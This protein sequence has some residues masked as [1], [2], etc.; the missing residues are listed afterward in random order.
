MKIVKSLEQS[1]LLIKGVSEKIQNEAKE[2][3][4][5][6]LRMLLGKLGARLIGNLLTAKGA[7]RA[8]KGTIRAG[9]NFWCHVIL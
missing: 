3:K 4:G 2:Q 5:R 9:Q 7:I 1:G 6:F 8:G